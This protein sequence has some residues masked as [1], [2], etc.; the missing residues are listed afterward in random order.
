MADRTFTAGAPAESIAIRATI[1][2]AGTRDAMTGIHCFDE[3]VLTPTFCLPWDLDPRVTPVSHS[4]EGAQQRLRELMAA[5][6]QTKLETAR[7]LGHM[8]VVPPQWQRL[9]SLL[10]G[11]RTWTS[12]SPAVTR[13]LEE[14]YFSPATEGVVNA[15]GDPFHMSRANMARGQIATGVTEFKLDRAHVSVYIALKVVTDGLRSLFHAVSLALWGVHDNS[16]VLETAV[17]STLADIQPAAALQARFFTELRRMTQSLVAPSPAVWESA[18]KSINEVPQLH[19]FVLCNAIKRPIIVYAEDEGCS[20]RGIYLPL[21]WADLTGQIPCEHNLHLLNPV[22]LS[23][24][25]VTRLFNPL[26]TFQG[27]QHFRDP[28]MSSRT[29]VVTE[30]GQLLPV[31]FLLDGEVGQEMA[32]LFRTMHLDRLAVEVEVGSPLFNPPHFGP[33][34]PPAAVQDLKQILCAR[35]ILEPLPREI[36]LLRSQR[37]VEPGI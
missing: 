7:V 35:Q 29:P 28:T 1:I 34:P 25:A 5:D 3:S 20:V 4:K 14:L 16:H 9:E 8:W 24:D 13:F 19:V 23:F 17:M 26:V 21:L 33:G 30:Q 6:Q 32:L 12:F 27:Q 15:P 18:T 2:Q 37:T 10:D 36:E 11:S 31:R 22:L